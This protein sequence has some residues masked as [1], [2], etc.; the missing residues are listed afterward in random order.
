MSDPELVG[1][2]GADHAK[3]VEHGP[4]WRSG[5]EPLVGGQR[6][7]AL[8]KTPKLSTFCPFSY[9]KLAKS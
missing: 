3:R 9:K 6:R 2:K 8:L 1:G 7:K 5:V 4:K